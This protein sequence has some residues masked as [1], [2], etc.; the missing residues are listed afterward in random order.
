VFPFQWFV[1]ALCSWILREQEEVIAFLREENRVL[2]AHLGGRRLQLS[3]E[4]R[5]RLARLGHQLGRAA[6]VQV[7]TIATA[8]TIL[9][10][11]RELTGR[12]CTHIGRRA[13]RPRIQTHLRALIL[14]MASENDTWGYTRIQGAMKNLGHRVGRSTIARI[15]KA[16]G[17][18]PSRRRPMA[19]RT[20]VRAHWPALHAADVFMGEVCRLR[21]FLAFYTAL[22]AQ[23]HP[24]TSG[25][26]SGTIGRKRP[27]EAHATLDEQI[28]HELG[29]AHSDLRRGFEEGWWHEPAARHSGRA[30]APDVGRRAERRHRGTGRP[31][32]MKETP[33]IRSAA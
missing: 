33:L 21:R 1:G 17:V 22:I 9:R 20:F 28:D 7:A 14:R 27:A 31:A 6:L 25:R 19:W 16:H 26:F 5:R 10:W 32:S 4:E 18:P 11:H 13:G 2:R 23:L 29:A 15:L 24:P 30:R 8:D 3:D 12:T